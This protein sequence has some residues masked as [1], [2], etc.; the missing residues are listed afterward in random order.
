MILLVFAL[1]LNSAVMSHKLT[2]QQHGTNVHLGGQMSLYA[3]LPKFFMYS[4]HHLDSVGT[5]SGCITNDTG[6]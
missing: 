5:T 3:M 1:L 6:R 2:R 4:R